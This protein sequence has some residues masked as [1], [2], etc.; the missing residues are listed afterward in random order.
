[1]HPL[2]GRRV[3]VTG[4]GGFVGAN[5]V[6]ALTA[7]GART[8]AVVRPGSSRWRLEG[9]AGAAE[10][11]EADVTASDIAAVVGDV[12]PELA[13]GLAI[14]SG[15]PRDEKER[16]LQLETSVLG[17]ARLVEALAESGC[18][19]LVQLGSSL[20][21][22]PRERP[23]R[24][25]DLLTP[26][27]PRGAVKAAETLV[28]L[29][30]A[31]TLGIQAVVLRPFSIYGPWEDA[32][33]LVPAAIRAALDGD[34]LPLTGSGLVHDFIHVDDV[35]GAIMLALGEQA[36]LGGCI[37][38]VGTGVETSNEELVELVGSLVGRT[39]RVRAGAFPERPHDAR[40]WVADVDRA[41]RVLGWR[42]T[43]SLED[44][45]ARTIDW[46]RR[47]SRTTRVPAA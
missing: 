34:E 13:V 7:A 27:V 1:M 21:Y 23:L 26:T 10:V 25:D 30:W 29:T 33:R 14:R 41:A 40:R 28:C 35:V 46:Y 5:L 45:L 19:R 18:Q 44:G 32:A 9:V 31:R 39:V 37:V 43:T 6:A 11:H 47:T 8:A 17:T 38:N 36:D 2:E 12:R 22:G 24:E 15:H 16:A 4:A 42:S 3:L 20:E